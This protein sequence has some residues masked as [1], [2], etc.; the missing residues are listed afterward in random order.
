[1]EYNK[2][3]VWYFMHLKVNDPPGVERRG[4]EAGRER[5]R[6]AGLTYKGGG[7]GQIWLGGV[8]GCGSE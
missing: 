2:Q 5:G 6:G 1:M 4:H 8:S 7:E 3:H